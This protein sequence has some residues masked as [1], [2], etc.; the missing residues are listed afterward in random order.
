MGPLDGTGHGQ[1]LSPRARAAAEARDLE[2]ERRGL[3]PSMRSMPAP[4][5]LARP[6]DCQWI[7]SRSEN[8]RARDGRGSG[9]R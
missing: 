9:W 6:R 3:T 5:Y 1:R 2:V 7:V 8:D 4:D